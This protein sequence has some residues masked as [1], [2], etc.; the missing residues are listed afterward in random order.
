MIIHNRYRKTVR[1]IFSVWKKINK[2]RKL[3]MQILDRMYE[4]NKMRLF[5]KYL[6]FR[7]F[8]KELKEFQIEK[9]NRFR[10]E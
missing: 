9:A 5:L 2:M 6:E 4:K 3:S 7:K 10:Q 1:N 8:D